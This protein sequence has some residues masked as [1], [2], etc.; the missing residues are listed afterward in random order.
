MFSFQDMC[1]VSQ[2]QIVLH[3]VD[4]IRLMFHFMN[5]LY[6]NQ[7]GKPLTLSLCC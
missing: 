5:D 4:C 1:D 3:T 2:A 7:Q 6:E